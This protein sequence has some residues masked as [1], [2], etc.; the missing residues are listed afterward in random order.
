M[1]KVIEAAPLVPTFSTEEGKFHDLGC[2]RVLS[3]DPLL[4]RSMTRKEEK[5][6]RRK[7]GTV[8]CRNC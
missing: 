4:K 3:T 2:E 1:G 5:E 6:K 7:E 8:I